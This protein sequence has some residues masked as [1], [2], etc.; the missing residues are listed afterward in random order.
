MR[1]KGEFTLEAAVIFP[2]ITAIIVGIIILDFTL[3]DRLLGDVSKILGGIRYYESETFYY[4]AGFQQIR[5]QQIACSPVFGED[6]EFAQKQKQVISNI[7][8][9]YY[10]KNKIGFEPQFTKTD[11]GKVFD[12]NDNAALVRAGGKVVQVI[13]GD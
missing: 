10:L 9:D 5:P 12:M 8:A 1:L 6:K 13:G 7:T 3:H 4:D 11:I 2:L